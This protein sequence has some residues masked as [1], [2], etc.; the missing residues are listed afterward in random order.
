C[1]SIFSAAASPARARCRRSALFASGA[2]SRAAGLSGGG[3]ASVRAE[4]MTNPVPTP[5]N[6]DSVAT[7]STK[8]ASA[9]GSGITTLPS[10]SFCPSSAT[11]V[12]VP[13]AELLGPE[14]PTGSGEANRLDDPG[15]AADGGGNEPFARSAPG[16][17]AS[18]AAATSGGSSVGGIN[19]ATGPPVATGRSGGGPDGAGEGAAGGV[20]HPASTKD[21]RM[22]SAGGAGFSRSTLPSIPRSA[23]ARARRRR[24]RPLFSISRKASTQRHTR[25]DRR[26]RV[27]PDAAPLALT[28]RRGRGR[29]R[30]G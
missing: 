30:Y 14:L 2:A 17:A 16:G 6:T 10:R 1:S 5:S 25:P 28:R 18:G 20:D 27:A 19:G 22:G 23:A 12:V 24:P 26:S 11:G 9:K 3:A 8:A 15:V 21:I 13:A 29:A 7:D 4:P